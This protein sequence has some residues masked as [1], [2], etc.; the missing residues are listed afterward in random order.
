MIEN[1]L[2]P[3]GLKHYSVT[4]TQSVTFEDTFAYN[5]EEAEE[6]ASNSFYGGGGQGALD[7]AH[8]EF[9]AEPTEED[10]QA[11]QEAYEAY[12]NEEPI[13]EPRG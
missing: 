12:W 4:I 5:K 6:L 8:I 2:A 13:A 3:K 9:N 10:R 1:K 11:V 7:D